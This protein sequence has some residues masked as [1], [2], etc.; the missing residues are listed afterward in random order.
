LMTSFATDEAVRELAEH[1][2]S[3][4]A[5][6]VTFPQL[7]SLRLTR[8]GE[9]FIGSDGKPSPYA[10]GHGDLTFALRRSGVLAD[11]LK[12]RGRVLYMSNADNVTAALEPAGIGAHSEA[13]AASALEVAAKESGDKG[14][15]PARVDGEPQIVESFRFPS[16]FDQNTIPVF[17]TNTFAFDAER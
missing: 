1:F 16:E 10:P 4:A 14:G 9:L 11:F 8:E 13:G 6:I 3:Q 7:I 12:A 15:A 17:N 5:P 2:Q